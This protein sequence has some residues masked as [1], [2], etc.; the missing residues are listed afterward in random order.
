MKPYTLSAVFIFS[1]LLCF[2]D[3]QDVLKRSD[4]LSD[5]GKHNDSL[6]M[7]QRVPVET[8]P[9]REQAELYWR[10][11]RATF[12]IGENSAQT[13][14]Q[15]SILALYCAAEA[16]ADKAISA[17][18]D[19]YQGYFWKS[20]SLGKWAQIKG[21]FDALAKVETIRDM[22]AHCLSLNPD[23]DLTYYA[24]AQLYTEL[25]GFPISFGDI[26][27]AVSLARLSI[28]AHMKAY[29]KGDIKEV[30]HDFYNELAK[31]LYKRNWSADKRNR[32][33][34]RKQDQYKR[35][36]N[37]L[38]RGFYYEGTVQ[39][40]NVPDREEARD[41]IRWVIRTLES[42]TRRTKNQNTSLERAKRI[43]KDIGA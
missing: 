3:I 27:Y 37:A 36:K 6:A 16:L 20:S 24:L 2:A 25:P 11:A 10:L 41:I 42:Q 28:D 9:R 38:E 7:L 17:S 39:L 14:K 1:A 19:A 40:K 23:H 26:D 12:G 21:G 33:Q 18:P 8:L 30:F 31:D 4:E 32:E 13:S 43:A 34:K 22:Y 15:E 29:E 35:A 5:E